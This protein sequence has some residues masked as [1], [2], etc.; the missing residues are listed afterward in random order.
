ML[1]GKVQSPKASAVRTHTHTH[2][3]A[4]RQVYKTV[5]VCECVCVCVYFVHKD[6]QMRWI[7][8]G[9]QK[10]FQVPKQIIVT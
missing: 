9:I 5:Y 2:A 1:P 8:R 10:M 6:I 3:R 7:G 4:H